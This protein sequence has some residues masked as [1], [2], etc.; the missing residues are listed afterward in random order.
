[1]KTEVRAE[2]IEGYHNRLKNKLYSLLCAKEEN[3]EWLS[4]LDNIII[5]LEG[6]PA[7]DRGINYLVL[8]YKINSLRYVDYKWFR[9]IIFDCMSLLSAKGD[10]KNGVL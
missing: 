4:F 8:Y 3:G 7:E 9:K 2:T 6:I 5:E 1:M 10:E